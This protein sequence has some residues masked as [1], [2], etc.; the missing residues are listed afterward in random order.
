MTVDNS[1]C[2]FPRLLTPPGRALLQ[3]LCLFAKERREI[4]EF[5]DFSM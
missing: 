3:S 4:L 1:E 5:S 2:N